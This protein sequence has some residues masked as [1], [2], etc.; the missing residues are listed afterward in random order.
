MKWSQFS[1]RFLLVE[2]MLIAIVL[3]SWQTYARLPNN[4]WNV[5]LAV[6]FLAAA[7]PAV[8]GLL[9][10]RGMRVGFGISIVFIICCITIIVV[11]TAYA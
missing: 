9:G 1:S 7:V 3:G 11:P 2:T 6:V 5:P 8:C 4:D 10:P